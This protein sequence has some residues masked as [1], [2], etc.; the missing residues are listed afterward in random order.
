MVQTLYPLT[1]QP[2]YKEKIWGG[3]RLYDLFQRPLPDGL[4]GE[5]WDVAAHKNGTSVVE[6]GPLA[7]RTLTEVTRDLGGDSFPLL[8]KLID[9]Q[10]DLSVQVHPDDEYVRTST[11]ERFGKT[12]MWYIVHSDPGAWI[13]WGLRPGVTKEGFTHA[14]KSGGAEL[15]SCLNRVPVKP[16]ELYPISAGL[17]HALG[18]GVVVAEL[19]QNSDTTYRVYDWDR[20]D[21]QGRARELHV[22]QAL[23]VIDFSPEALD[24]NYQMARCAHYFQMQVLE[25]PQAYE[26]E[27]R[28][29]YQI[30]T[31]LQGQARISWNGRE[32]PLASGQSCLIPP[33]IGFCDLSADGIVLCGSS[34]IME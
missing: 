11:G 12:E 17:V 33:G 4:I 31:S 24:P 7:G 3:R 25:K 19:Q 34:T 26:L 14:L 10:Q 1:F 20:V 29:G 23:E 5:S 32:L 21:A 22:E 13:V 8:F 30:L 2:I 27:P 18:A 28:Q 6:N 15:L 16:G 9:A